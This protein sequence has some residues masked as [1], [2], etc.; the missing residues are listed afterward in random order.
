VTTPLRILTKA[1]WAA[2]ES[3]TLLFELTVD[4]DIAS[5]EGA[6]LS[7]LTMHPVCRIILRSTSDAWTGRHGW[8]FTELLERFHL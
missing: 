2:N 3:F 8:F 6:T 1:E 7:F 4:F 5:G